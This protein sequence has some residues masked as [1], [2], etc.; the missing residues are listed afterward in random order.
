MRTLRSLIANPLNTSDERFESIEPLLLVVKDDLQRLEE[1]EVF[2]YKKSKIANVNSLGEMVDHMA[3][4]NQY[5]TEVIVALEA[6]LDAIY[7]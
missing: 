4:N 1:I 6:R 2:D 5:I 3:K 7:K